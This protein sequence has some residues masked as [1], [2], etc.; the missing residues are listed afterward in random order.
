MP[1]TYVFRNSAHYWLLGGLFLATSLYGP[2]Y[3][4][5]KLRY[6]A[7][8]DPFFL[9]TC[10]VIWVVLELMNFAAHWTL[11]NLRPKG[12]RTRG[13]PR[14]PLFAKVSCPNY[15]T[16]IAVWSVVWFMTGDFWCTSF[17]LVSFHPHSLTQQL[18]KSWFFPSSL[19]PP[20]KSI[21][22][23]RASRRRLHRRGCGH[24]GQMGNW[25]APQVQ[26][27]F[28]RQVPSWSEGHLPV[29]FVGIQSAEAL[30]TGVVRLLRLL[31]FSTLQ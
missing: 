17:S 15:T 7:R 26:G 14:G 19:A 27:R 3:G 23:L 1:F 8:D 24:N 31:R 2:W 28:W 13:I 18:L 10:V 20:V 21:L 9:N 16:E 4:S 6:T 12:T 29:D 30:G 11:M 22:I 5:L 25:K